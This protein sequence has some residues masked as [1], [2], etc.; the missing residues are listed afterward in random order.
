MQIGYRPKTNS[1]DGLTP[2]LFEQYVI[3]L[4]FFG[5]NQIELIPHSFDDA[6]YSPHFSLSHT[7]MN[8][9]MSQI[10]NKYGL[11]V[12]LWY[13]ACNPADPHSNKGCVSG[14]Y[15]NATVMAAAIAD[16]NTTF[17][18]M[19]RVNTLFLN[20]GDP[21]AQTPDDLVMIAK[22]ARK[23]LLLHHP[24]ADVWV[25]PQVHPRSRSH[26]RILI[27]THIYSG[28]DAG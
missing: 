23:I 27:P 22:A 16:W 8:V 4:A 5:V 15:H 21:G 1:Y 3:D 26:P 24:A 28:L 9:A 11:N 10:V 2:E 25:C 12:S 14:D 6:P 18:S 7:D 17:A 20:A 19:E 13:P